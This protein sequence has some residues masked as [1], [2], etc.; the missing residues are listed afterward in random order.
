MIGFT[1]TTYIYLRVIYTS[2]KFYKYYKILVFT[3]ISIANFLQ[4]Q[5][6]IWLINIPNFAW[7][8]QILYV[9]YKK[10]IYPTYPIHGTYTSLLT[11]Y[12]QNSHIKCTQILT[13]PTKVT[14]SMFTIK[15]KQIPPIL[16]NIQNSP[17]LPWNPY[18]TC[19]PHSTYPHILTFYTSHTSNKSI[20][21]FL[22]QPNL[23]YCP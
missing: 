13:P 22:F 12:Q 20:Q 11:H 21:T 10:T 14:H 1:P 4:N 17:Y 3:V 5:H 8:L 6:I 7:I 2:Y 9:L 19:A 15:P 23:K 18:M 16:I